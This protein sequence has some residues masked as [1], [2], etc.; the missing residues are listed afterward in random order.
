MRHLSL[1]C[2]LLSVITLLQ[3]PFAVSAAGRVMPLYNGGEWY[4]IDGNRINC[5][6]GSIIKADS[7]YY[8]Y[9]EHRPGFDA[10]YQKGVACYSSPDLVNWKNEGIA[11]AVVDDTA[12]VMQRGCTI[13]RPK[14][15]FNPKTGKY[16]MWFHHELKG[17]GYD[18]A[19]Y[20]VAVSESPAGPFRLLRSQRANPG[21]YPANLARKFRGYKWDEADG[22]WWTPEWR[23]A[24]EEGMFA[25]RDREGGQMSRDMTLFVDDDGK[26][27]HI[28][29]SEENLTLHIAPLTPDYTAHTGKYVRLFPG[30]HNEAPVLFKHGGKYWMI[31]SGCTGWDPNEARLFSADN[32]MGEWTR[33][34]TPFVGEGSETTLGSQ[35]AFPLVVDGEIYFFAD[36]WRPRRLADS[37]YKCLPVE[38]DADGMPVIK[39]VDIAPA[40]NKGPGGKRLVWSDEFDRDGRLDSLYWNYENGFERNHEDQWYQPDNAYCRDGVLVL[41]A[42][43]ECRPNPGYSEDASVADWRASRPVIGYTSASVNTRGKKEFRY[44]TLEVRARIPVAPGAWPAIWTLG[45]DMPWPSNG[46]ID[47]M[48][49]YRID[50]VP[51]ILANAA[52]GTDKE[53]DAKWHTV[54]VPFEHF[55]AKDSDWASKFHIWRMDWDEDYLR[56]YLDDKLIHETALAGTFNGAIGKGSNPMRQPHYVLLDLALG[57]DHGGDIADDALPMKYEIDYVRIYQ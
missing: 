19:H 56:I 8:W 43:K 34:P 44:G 54:A 11:L 2:F 33:H 27:Y 22:E 1:S 15:V 55:T 50:G 37:R 29:S 49:Y 35:G 6:G 41:E 12:S 45:C 30:G 24:V 13:E 3:L 46:E 40:L 31:C 20:G 57:G 18:A 5:H 38:F 21:K 17:R 39:D 51:H 26:A 9:G 25:E 48:E 4:D 23:R 16:V 28:Y 47:V 32:I 10:A 42:R 53:Y 52:W 36:Q 14:V 7:L